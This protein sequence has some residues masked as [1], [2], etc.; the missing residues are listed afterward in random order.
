MGAD[1][2]GRVAFLLALVIIGAAAAVSAGS[3]ACLQAAR[4]G[5]WSNVNWGL[6]GVAGA[7][8]VGAV[9]GGAT[10]GVGTLV[11]G[12]GGAALAGSAGSAASYSTSAIVGQS[13]FTA[14]GLAKSMAIGA[15]AGAV[16]GAVTG[17]LGSGL[18]SQIAGSAAGG[19]TAFT[20]SVLMGDDATAEGFALSIGMGVA[21]ALANYGMVNGAQALITPTAPAP[22]AAPTPNAPPFKTAGGMTAPSVPMPARAPEPAPIPN[23]EPKPVRGKLNLPV[24][25]ITVFKADTLVAEV[26]PAPTRQGSTSV[27]HGRN[28]AQAAVQAG[29]EAASA[30]QAAHVA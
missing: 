22:K 5:G 1:A 17:E 15:V 12:V 8:I 3:S 6:K 4:N 13:E 29:N 24:Q 14:G 21:G 10:L 25:E 11:G 26:P 30:A 19:A 7:A 20:G 16:S 2:D 9:A 23:P 18:L 27:R 28:N